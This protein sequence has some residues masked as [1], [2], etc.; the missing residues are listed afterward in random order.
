MIA[1]LATPRTIVGMALAT[2]WISLLFRYRATH[3]AELAGGEVTTIDGLLFAT[4]SRIHAVIGSYGEAGRTFYRTTELTLDVVFPLVY[5]LCLLSALAWTVPRA[6]P[7]RPVL[8]RAARALPL[9]GAAADLFE[10]ACIVI[11]LSAYPREVP[12]V[13]VL[14]I[15]ATPVKYVAVVGAVVLLVVAFVHWARGPAPARAR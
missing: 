8:E 4:P 1:R 6:F 3:L 7:A 5:A 12:V 15:V 14:T 2:V 13:P 11:L 10:N 9:A